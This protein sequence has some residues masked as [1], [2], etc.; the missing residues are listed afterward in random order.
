MNARSIGSMLARV[1]VNYLAGLALLMLL[2][3]SDCSHQRHVN[4]R[5]S[6]TEAVGKH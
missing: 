3:A 4:P 5:G 2:F 1:G 6:D